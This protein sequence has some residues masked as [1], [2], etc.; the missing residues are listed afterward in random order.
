MKAPCITK[1]TNLNKFIY[2]KLKINHVS[3]VS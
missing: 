1:Q 2:E 3:K